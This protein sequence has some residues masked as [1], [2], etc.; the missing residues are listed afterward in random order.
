[1][2]P[3]PWSD[4]L[5]HAGVLLVALAIDRY[6]G[7]PPNRW[8]PVVWMGTLIGRARAAAPPHPA[9]AFA[10][11]LGMALGVPAL[12]ALLALPVQLP[13]VGPVWAVFLVT[14]CIAVRGLTSAGERLA[15]SIDHG[16]LD[17]ARTDLGWLCSRDP[18]HLDA[19]ALTAAATES[20]A[21]NSSDSF[22]APPF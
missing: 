20:V 10:W 2:S 13:R 6:L 12:F 9:L 15:R 8:H 19:V 5:A 4:P 18:T 11:G 22:V 1:M 21:E 14:S 16:A 7:E 17:R 3:W